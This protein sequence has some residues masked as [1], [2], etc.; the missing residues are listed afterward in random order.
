MCQLPLSHFLSLCLWNKPQN[1]SLV[2]KWASSLFKSSVVLLLFGRRHTVMFLHSHKSFLQWFLLQ[3]YIIKSYYTPRWRLGFI[4]IVISSVVWGL[5]CL[6]T[7][8]A[9][10]WWSFVITHAQ[11]ISSQLW[12]L[13]VLIK[14][15][16]VQFWRGR[17]VEDYIILQFRNNFFFI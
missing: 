16:N 11:Y 17:N 2:G 7:V 6:L 12:F 5:A 15:C 4:S 9:T 8:T 10:F 3:N 13:K 1:Y 14:L